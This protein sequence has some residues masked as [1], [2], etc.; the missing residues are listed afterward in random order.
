MFDDEAQFCAGQNHHSYT[1]ILYSS[2]P[3]YPNVSDE[4]H[5]LIFRGLTHLNSPHFS[6]GE[7][8]VV[9]L[10]AFGEAATEA[11][12]LCLETGEVWG[13]AEMTLAVK[14]KAT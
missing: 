4:L 10:G 7:L 14:V 13:F 8:A 3:R 1:Q 6:L 2:I 12:Q 11:L 5:F 9:P